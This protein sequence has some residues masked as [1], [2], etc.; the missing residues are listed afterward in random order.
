MIFVSPYIPLAGLYT[1]FSLKKIG[2]TEKKTKFVY[3]LGLFFFFLVTATLKI[4]VV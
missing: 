4:T 1:I 3:F 2:E